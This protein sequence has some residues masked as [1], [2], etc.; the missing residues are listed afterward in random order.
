MVRSTWS[1]DGSD[2]EKKSRGE[3]DLTVMLYA[4]SSLSDQ[5]L[6]D[7]AERIALAISVLIF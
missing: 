5:S 4:M 7:L 6:L 3:V 1:S 2:A